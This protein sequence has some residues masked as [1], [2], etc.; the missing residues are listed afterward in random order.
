MRVTATA[1]AER[2]PSELARTFALARAHGPRR[3]GW[4][5]VRACWWLAVVAAAIG[6]VWVGWYSIDPSTVRPAAADLPRPWGIALPVLLGCAGVVLALLLLLAH[7]PIAAARARRLRTRVQRRLR[8]AAAVVAGETVARL[9]A[10][11]TEHDAARV[12]LIEAG[13]ARE[14]RLSHSEPERHATRPGTR[15]VTRPNS[16]SNKRGITAWPPEAGSE[17]EA[18][19]EGTPHPAAPDLD[20]VPG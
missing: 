8:D 7:R 19:G 20:H 6:V 14:F 5:A 10:V 4:W 9:R 3:G 18:D 13:H 1:A 11:L 2:V 17:R 15:S 16:G 12:A